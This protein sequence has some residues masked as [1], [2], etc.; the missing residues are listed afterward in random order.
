MQKYTTKI[1]PEEVFI[2]VYG[3]MKNKHPI[4]FEKIMA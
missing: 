1:Q 4:N 2:T 3:I